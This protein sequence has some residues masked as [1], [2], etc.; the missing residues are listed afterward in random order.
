MI[1]H[2]LRKG[3]N[4]M[5]VVEDLEKLKQLKDNGAITESEFETEKSKILNGSINNNNSVSN[6]EKGKTQAIIGLILGLVSIIAWYIPL[7]GFPVTIIGIIFSA[8]GMKSQN[9]KGKAIA[10]LTL[11]IIFLVVTIINSFLGAILATNLYYYF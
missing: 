1:R 11:S 8:I 3:V 10:G 9:N 7:L 2:F 4:K 6:T 5:G